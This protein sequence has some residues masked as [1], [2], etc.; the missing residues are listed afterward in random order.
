MVASCPKLSPLAGNTMGELAT[1]LVEV[2]ET[3][4]ACVTAVGIKLE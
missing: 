2:A 1:K 4:Y 3:Y